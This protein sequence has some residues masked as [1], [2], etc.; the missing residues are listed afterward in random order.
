MNVLEFLTDELHYI[1][2]K[3]SVQLESVSSFTGLDPDNLQRVYSQE[4][5]KN[6]YWIPWTD[7]LG[8]WITADGCDVVVLMTNNIDPQDLEQPLLTGLASVVAGTCLNL[9]GQIAIHANAVS[10]MGLAVGFIGYSG[11]GKSTL[12]AYCS[13]RGAGFITDDVLVISPE[14]MVSL[15]N[16]RLKLYPHTGQQLGLDISQQTDYKIYFQPDAIGA[17]ILQKSVPIGI[18]YLL[19]ESEEGKLYSEEVA[20][21]QSMFEL[22]THSYSASDIIPDSPGLLDVYAD[23]INKTPIR[24]LYYPRDFAELPKVYDFLVNEVAELQQ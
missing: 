18:L 23:L 8:A 17:A 19:A 16:H 4:Y 6:R 9:Q 7:D 21:S 5:G 15:G 12:S 3:I 13:S 14:G 11:M 10:L 24:K 22:L 2:Q 1:P 20:P